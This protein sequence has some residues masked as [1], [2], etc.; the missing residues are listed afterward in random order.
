[1]SFANADRAPYSAIVDRPKFTL[2]NGARIAV[3][4]VPNVEHYEFLPG[5]TRVRDPWPRSPHPDILSY[6][7]RDYG[8]RVGLWRMM[9]VMDA[10]DV[11]GTLSLS[12]ANF[13]MYPEIME[14]CE[15]RRWDVMSHGMYNSRYHWGYSE[16]E[17]RAAIAECMELHQTLLGRPLTGWFSPAASWTLNTPDLIAE[18]GITYYCDWYHD[19]QPFPMRTRSGK[20]L[21]TIPY[22]MDVN[23]AIVLHRQQFEAADFE[24]MMIRAFDVLYREGDTQPRVLCLALHPFVM[25]QPH[26]IKHLERALAH[27]TKHEG[28]WMATGQEI[29]DWYIHHHLAPM[30]AHLG[31]EQGA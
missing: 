3:W 26:R 28:V 9:E 22:T 15:A 11:R 27:I 2:P 19:D 6:G 20:P 18:A 29:A 1:M 24:R 17:E 12:M 25:G 31:W 16:D 13:A 23:D 7:I 10:H 5:P 4:V 8:N 14:A 30:K 21:I